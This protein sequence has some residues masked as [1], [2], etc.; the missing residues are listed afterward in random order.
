MS[1]QTATAAKK[2]VPKTS[3]KKSGQ[4]ALGDLPAQIT[5][6]VATAAGALAEKASA[7]SWKPWATT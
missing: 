5:G 2:A 7:G 3:T 1:K 4:E 6:T